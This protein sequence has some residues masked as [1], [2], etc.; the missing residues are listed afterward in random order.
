MIYI[1]IPTVDLYGKFVGKYTVRPMD[2]SWDIV[3]RHESFTVPHDRPGLLGMCCHGKE[4]AV[5]TPYVRHNQNREFEV[6][7][8]PK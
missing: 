8:Y 6:S 3:A 1:Y 4:I 7:L 2:P 5:R